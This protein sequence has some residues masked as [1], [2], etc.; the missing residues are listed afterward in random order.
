MFVTHPLRGAWIVVAALVIASCPFREA[1]SADQA[2]CG[3]LPC[4][5]NGVPYI[6]EA[7]TIVVMP[8]EKFSVE[9]KIE[10]DKVVGITPRRDPKAPGGIMLSVMVENGATALIWGNHLDR[11]VRLDAVS[12]GPMRVAIDRG[13]CTLPPNRY[14]YGLWRFVVDA[15]EV[16]GFS[17]TSA[18]GVKCD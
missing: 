5:A 16:T 7:G 4:R 8:G 11:P 17:F 3:E 13:A 12:R 15:V 9:L 14:T 18:E 2:S 10:G 1:R 6:A